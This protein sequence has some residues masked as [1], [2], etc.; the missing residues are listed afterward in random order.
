MPMTIHIID[1]SKASLVMSSEAFKD[2]IPGTVVTYS[3]TAKEGLA[4]VL[5]KMGEG[6]QGAPE[7]LVVD[8]DL[9]DADG[10]SLIK[11][12]RKFY[13]GPIFMT[14]Y[15]DKIVDY[16]VREELFH[17][18]DACCWI[19]KPVRYDVLEQR[20][21]QFLVN[22]H[23]LGKRFDVAFPSLMVGKGEGRGKR[24][25]KFEGQLVNI[26]MGGLGMV[27]QGAAKL[28]RDEEFLVSMGVPKGMIEGAT[29]ISVL[30]PLLNPPKAAQ[31]A[32]K[33]GAKAAVIS[34]G[35]ANVKI[36]KLTP[37]QKAKEVARIKLEE[38]ARLRAEEMET[39]A[40]QKALA[41]S[42]QNLEEYK[43]KA[44]VAWVGDGGR[45]V[46]LQF[47]KIPDSQRRQIEVFLKGL[48]V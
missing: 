11:E 39:A 38:K 24:A 3:Y 37:A 21:E 30:K 48:S 42:A 44:T 16:A 8:F 2:K 27:F 33:A 9:P 36:A 46:G 10:V 7:A 34:V 4:F 47:A 45:T 41:A 22:R 40:N 43:V 1:S 28:K 23:R 5:D 26:S 29:A 12:L 25:P 31:G 6:R 17:Y 18:H 15:P 13:K 20:I 14:A 32:A 35:K 19:P